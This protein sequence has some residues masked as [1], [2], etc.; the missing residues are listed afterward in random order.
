[1]PS[2]EFLNFQNIIGNNGTLTT[3]IEGSG[4]DPAED[5]EE[6]SLFENSLYYDSSDFETYLQQRPNSFIV[7]SL[8]C[9][10]LLAKFDCLKMYLDSYNNESFNISALC[11]QETWLTE[12]SDLSLIQIP[13]YNLI[14]LGR[15]CSAHSGLAIY[16]H[17]NYQ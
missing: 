7:Y 13:G 9:Q 17:Q 16:L 10:S 3:Q 15:S 4:L 14:H 11:L 12:G 8:N 6:P 5:S 1:M 2:E